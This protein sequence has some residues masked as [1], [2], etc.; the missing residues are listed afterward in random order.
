MYE[1]PQ[2]G[3]D[4]RFQ[5]VEQVQP[6]NGGFVGG[7]SADLNNQYG[8]PP[9]SHPTGPQPPPHLPPRPFEQQSQYRPDGVPPH[10]HDGF[11]YGGNAINGRI[12]GRQDSRRS[13]V[14]SSS[15][16][17]QLSAVERSHI[18]RS[19]RM[20]PVLQ[21]MVGPLLK[22]DTVD[23]KGVWHGA[24]LIVSKY[25]LLSESLYSRQF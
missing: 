7:F 8:A 6:L 12:S 22:Y 5:P 15:S 21:Y 18:L 17:T 24:C 13:D 2:R 14:S 9:P 11:I 10:G 20:N 16:L 3:P 4:G 25:S 1:N 19:I 23:E